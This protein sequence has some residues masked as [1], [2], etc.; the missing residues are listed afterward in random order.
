MINLSAAK[1][2]SPICFAALLVACGGSD[3]NTPNPPNGL[4]VVIS[5]N[6]NGL[7]V[8]KTVVLQNNGGDNLSISNNGKFSF[9]KLI[10]F[11]GNY[12]VT[13]S[14]QPQGQS[15]SV[16]NGKGKAASHVMNVVVECVSTDGSLPPGPQTGSEACLD[17]PNLRK[18]GNSWTIHHDDYFDKNTVMGNSSFRGQ[19]ALRTRTETSNGIVSDRYTNLSGGTSYAY[20]AVVSQPFWHETY[21]TPAHASPVSLPLNQTYTVTTET[22]TQ[23]QNSPLHKVQLTHTMTYLGRETIVTSFGAFEACKF[24]YTSEG[25]GVPKTAWT[26]WYA[27]SGK[28]A[29]LVLQSAHEGTTEQPSAIEVNWN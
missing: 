13:V 27:A 26:D 11:Q 6:V 7:A 4:G 14:A 22:T 12:D 17:A 24:E 19:S 23:Q 9:G 25:P 3:D 1:R 15:C 8:N 10:D 16:S 29:G 28:L 2:I 18:T 20:G 5:G 21:Y